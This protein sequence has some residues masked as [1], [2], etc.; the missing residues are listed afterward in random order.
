MA[1]QRLGFVILLCVLVDFSNPMLPGSVR[2]DPSESIEGIHGGSAGHISYPSS[3]QA[4]Q[5]ARHQLQQRPWI[6][7][8]RSTHLAAPGR[9]WFVTVR[10]LRHQSD[11][12]TSSPTEDH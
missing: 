1:V 2:L 9:R 8:P 10:P 7:Q 5:P 4:R 12:L 11:D 3:L 6:V